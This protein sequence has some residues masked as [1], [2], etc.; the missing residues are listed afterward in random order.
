M[1]S[2]R[3]IS[4]RDVHIFGLL[5]RQMLAEEGEQLAPGIHALFGPVDRPVPIEEAVASTVVAMEFVRLAVLLEFGLVLVHLF[6]A[7]CAV[8]IAEDADQRTRK[9]LR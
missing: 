4:M 3:S 9:I 7:R 2:A 5:F 1:P 8:V 6:G